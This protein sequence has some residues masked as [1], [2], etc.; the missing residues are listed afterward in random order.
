[1]FV[2]L[3]KGKSKLFC[4]HNAWDIRAKKSPYSYKKIWKSNLFHILDT[5]LQVLSNTKKNIWNPPCNK[6]LW[7]IML[8][9]RV[10]PERVGIFK[11]W[12][13]MWIPLNL[14][15]ISKPT[16]YGLNVHL[17]LYQYMKFHHLKTLEFHTGSIWKNIALSRVGHVTRGTFCPHAFYIGPS[18]NMTLLTIFQLFELGKC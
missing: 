14:H 1:M 3:Q 10:G 15:T 12:L 2:F 11:L 16:L 9:S 6:K 13:W 5:L 18:P 8:A 7:D 4:R 17:V